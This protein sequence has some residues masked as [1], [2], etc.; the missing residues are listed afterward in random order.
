MFVRTTKL[1]KLCCLLCLALLK[2][3]KD[4]NSMEKNTSSQDMVLKITRACVCSSRTNAYSSC[5]LPR[6]IVISA[7][8]TAQRGQ[9]QQQLGGTSINLLPFAFLY[10][11]KHK[12]I[13]QKYLSPFAI[14]RPT[15]PRSH[16]IILHA[17]PVVA[18]CFMLT[19]TSTHG[20][21]APL[22]PDAFI[23]YG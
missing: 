20:I 23:A 15:A 9:S 10:C 3:R 22:C 5:S 19:P 2:K 4:S 13:F 14:G 17:I 8:A 16:L 11:K 12:N 1:C 18:R 6:R 21:S 7:D